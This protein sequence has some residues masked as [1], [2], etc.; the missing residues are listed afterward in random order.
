[1]IVVV[2][3]INLDLV[4]RVAR[5]PRA[6]ETLAGTAFASLPGGKGA[7]Q[8]LAAR[9]A[10]A[11][12]A[13]VGAVGDD[14]FAGPALALLRADG[15]DVSGVRTVA[16]PTGLALIHVDDAGENAITVIAG[17]NATVTTQALPAAKLR[18]ATSVVMALEIPLETVVAT[19]AAA[20]AAG[21]RTI[22]NAAPATPLPRALLA[23]IDVLVVNESEAAAV[24]A[25]LGLPA[26]PAAFASALQ[27]VHGPATVVTL[28][29]R[30]AVAAH[31]EGSTALRAP[32]VAVVDTVGAGD[33]FVGALA[34]ALDRGVSLEGALRE[35]LAAGSLAC[36]RAGAQPSM[37]LRADI[38]RLAAS[39]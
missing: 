4:V 20:R 33:A 7:N 15:V 19:A 28:G 38:A 14:A 2:G 31:R 12:V 22:L 5:L 37:P 30:G 11:D 9:R 13:L 17:A 34:A 18:A 27:A 6:G 29:A 32:A 23:A 21:V 3:S 36:T 25:A 24:A 10:G 39:I 16:A 1:M 35:G 26:A 8:A